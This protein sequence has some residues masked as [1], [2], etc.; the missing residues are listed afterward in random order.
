MKKLFLLL[1]L[2]SLCFGQGAHRISQVVV[3]GNG[4]SANVSPGSKILVCAPNTGCKTAA[5]IFLDA[6]L[7]TPTFNPVTADGSGN[8][9]YYIASGCVDEQISSPGQGTIFVPNVCPFSGQGGGGGGLNPGAQ[10]QVV[11][12]PAAGTQGGPTNITVDTATKNNLTIPNAITSAVDNQVFQANTATVSGVQATITAAGTTGS[13]VIPKTNS[14]KSGYTNPNNIAID[15]LKYG[16]ISHFAQGVPV[17]EFGCAEDNSTDDRACI[18]AAINY[19][20]SSGI[21]K[22]DFTPGA[23]YKV[24]SI[25]GTIPL[26]WDN[27]LCPAAGTTVNGAPCTTITAETPAQQAYSLWV[28]GNVI[29]NMNGAILDGT[30]LTGITAAAPSAPAMILCASVLTVSNVVV[31]TYGGCVSESI[32]DGS[33]AHAFIGILIPGV[34]SFS[35]FDDL[36]I[37]SGG[38]AML[39]HIWD[40]SFMTDINITAE[41]TGIIVGGWYTNRTNNGVVVAG[42]TTESGGYADG[43]V[44]TNIRFSGAGKFLASHAN[45]DNYFA[46]FIYKTQNQGNGRMVDVQGT[47]SPNGPGSYGSLLPYRGIFGNAVMINSRYG[48]QDNG[49][50]VNTIQSKAAARYNLYVAAPLNSSYI[51]TLGGEGD[52]LC[53]DGAHFVGDPVNCPDP[54]GA[55]NIAPGLV[56]FAAGSSY[57]TVIDAG[58]LPAYAAN[59]A[60]AGISTTVIGSGVEN[61]Q[62]TAPNQ[63]AISGGLGLSVGHEAVSGQFIFQKSIAL[64]PGGTV[65]SGS[66]DVWTAKQLDN[67][68]TGIGGFLDWTHASI[69]NDTGFSFRVPYLTLASRVQPTCDA[70]ASGYFGHAGWLNYVAGGAGVADIAQICMKDASNI[71]SWRS[72]LNSNIFTSLTLG[73]SQSLTGVQGTTGAKIAAASGTFTTNHLRMSNATGDE[74]DSSVAGFTGT[75]APTTTLSVSNGIVT[76]CS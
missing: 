12:Y 15:D 16:V 7:T 74:V 27:G 40:S 63:L 45:T 32:R 22:V 61:S 34:A 33:I 41:E 70:A 59:I 19:A 1:L 62:T 6:G 14:I 37:G 50:Q 4:I 44:A 43:F 51:S 56:N 11:F 8:Y 18:Q 13:V 29:L 31:P 66:G 39:I 67:V 20:V 64:T 17:R 38:I 73:G 47:S 36:T 2:P 28:P 25:G 46:T 52:G 5:S 65:P 75:C 3:K 76:G 21:R 10:Q 30:Y 68:T 71:Y 35:H 26:P 54:W 58:A 42:N 69:I 9:D 53:D 24:S 23:I 55:G 57:T 49:M 48:R 60:G 72:L